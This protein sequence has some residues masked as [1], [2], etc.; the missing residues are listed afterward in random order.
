[1][2]FLQRTDFMQSCITHSL[3]NRESHGYRAVLRICVGLNG[4][5]KIKKKISSRQN[6]TKCAIIKEYNLF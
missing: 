4:Y 5:I 2:N 3:K 6:S 1:M